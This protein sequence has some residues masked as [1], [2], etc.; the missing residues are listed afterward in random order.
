MSVVRVIATGD[1]IL[2]RKISGTV[3]PKFDQLVELLRSSDVAITNLEMVFPPGRRTASATYHG[4][5]LAVDPNL[6]SEFEWMGFNLYGLANN[7]ATDYGTNGLESSLAEL[8]A[9]NFAWAGAGRTLREARRPVYF[10]TPDAR[11]AYIAATSSNS[12]LSAAADPGLADIG[13]P[14]ISPMRLQKTYFI[15][16]ENYEELRGALA[17]AGVDVNATG[18]TAPGVILPYP[19]RNIWEPPPPD[20]FA[21]EGIHFAPADKSHIHTW[22]IDRD[23]QALKEVVSEARRQADL[24]FVGLHCHEGIDGRWNTE[25]PAEFMQPL[26]HALVNAGAHA[27][28]AHGPHM[29]R[30]I[31]L[32]HGRPICYSLGN[33]IFTLE[34]IDSFPAEIYEQQGMPA[35]ATAADLYDRLTGYKA[36][37]RFWESVVVR[38][39]FEGDELTDSE[40]VPI[41]LGNEHPRSRRG[42]PVLA[43]ESDGERILANLDALSREFGTRIDTTVA[44]GR[45]VGRL[46]SA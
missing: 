9:R 25:R 15:R 42:C 16:H 35:N 21:V 14:G 3:Q 40:I 13:R 7:H 20:G 32:Y 31:E 19:D 12:R 41:T 39:S 2:T 30:G 36:E 45:A 29:L 4:T 26:A 17:G 10:E 46:G 6:L 38:F 8:E 23:I 43:N 5:P 24:V 18:T 11:V 1:S 22:A 44:D 28:L 27:I 34:T 37:Q 33:F